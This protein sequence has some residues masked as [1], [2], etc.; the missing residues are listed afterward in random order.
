MTTLKQMYYLEQLEQINMKLKIGQ[1]DDKIW[2][3]LDLKLCD[4]KD[5]KIRQ[6]KKVCDQ[7]EI[8]ITELNKRIKGLIKGL[9]NE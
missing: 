9:I 1:L 2:K 8:K 3:Q 4:Q 7:K 6:L 5:F